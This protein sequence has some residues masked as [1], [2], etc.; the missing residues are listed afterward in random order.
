MVAI[1][2]SNK[3]WSCLDDSMLL[4]CQE[5]RKLENNFNGLK[6]LHILRGKNEVTNELAKLGSSWAMVL[7]GV[8]LQKLHEP[9]ISKALTKASKAAE[10][11]QDTPPQPSSITESPKVMEIHSNWR[12]PFMIN[13][14]IGGLPENKVK[15]E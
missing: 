10:S 14:R 3:E 15:C 12:T 5:L 1:N 9:T 13:F 11:S 6:Y 8:F 4:Y 2:Q 7:I